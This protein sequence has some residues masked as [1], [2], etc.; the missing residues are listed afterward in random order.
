[1]NIVVQ[2]QIGESPLHVAA[3]YGIHVPN[4]CEGSGASAT[5]QLYVTKGMHLM[6]EATDQEKDALDCAIEPR[7]ESRLA[8]RSII[9]AKDGYILN[10][11]LRKW[12]VSSTLFLRLQRMGISERTQSAVRGGIIPGAIIRNGGLTGDH[13][14]TSGIAARA[15]NYSD[16]HDDII[17]DY[18]NERRDHGSHP[19]W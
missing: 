2:G 14:G 8:C 13:G 9:V 1:M 17:V 18:S 3:K 16:T 12:S 4:A 5:C 10:L 7:A 6:K 11:S 15:S 19:P